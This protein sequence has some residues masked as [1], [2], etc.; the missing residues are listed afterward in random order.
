VL[1]VGLDLD[2]ASV[3]PHDLADDVQAQA[4]ALPLARRLLLTGAEWLEDVRQEVRRYRTALIVD[5]QDEIARLRI[6]VPP[7]PAQR[8]A[9]GWWAELQGIP[10]QVL[11]DLLEASFIPFTEG[12]PFGLVDDLPRRLE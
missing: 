7:R 12:S 9:R 8:H 1:G 10:E 4:H 2:G 11:D 5:P 3:C 6:V